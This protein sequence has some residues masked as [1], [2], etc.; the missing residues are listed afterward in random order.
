MLSRSYFTENL[1]ISYFE[2]A[3]SIN[4][5]I[6]RINHVKP[7]MD[8]ALLSGCSSGGLATLLH[9]D[10]FSARFPRTVSVKC[11]SDAGFFLDK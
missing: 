4:V 11:F 7:I 9:C 5:L 10:D 2:L 1:S 3:R 8:Q 6:T